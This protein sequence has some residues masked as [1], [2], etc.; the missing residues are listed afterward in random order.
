MSQK[1]VASVNKQSV[2][3]LDVV[4]CSEVV[5]DEEDEKKLEDDNADS[6]VVQDTVSSPRQNVD[7]FEIEPPSG[8]T[9]NEDGTTKTST[10]ADTTSLNAGETV[11]QEQVR[12]MTEELSSIQIHVGG[13]DIE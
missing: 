9:P 12:N 4:L 5:H 11:A 3:E 2:K 1:N 7:S 8:D 13:K 6:S 10:V